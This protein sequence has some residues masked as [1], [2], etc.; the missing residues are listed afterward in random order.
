MEYP[1]S[2]RRLA[3]PSIRFRVFRAPERLFQSLRSLIRPA[4]NRS[5][6]DYCLAKRGTNPFAGSLRFSPLGPI[7]TPISQSVHENERSCASQFGQE[8]PRCPRKLFDI[9]LLVVMARGGRVQACLRWRASHVL[10]PQ[11]FG[12]RTLSY[13]L[14]EGGKTSSM[15]S[16]CVC[17]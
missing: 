7:G 12:R 13:L 11:G 15:G 9:L 6:S 17:L 8:S 16:L 1:A 4:S 14:R 5:C 3:Q 10:C 2:H